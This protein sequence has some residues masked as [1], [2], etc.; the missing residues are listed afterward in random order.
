MVRSIG[1]AG[2]KG[3][4]PLGPCAVILAV[5]GILVVGMVATT[6]VAMVGGYSPDETH[7]REIV[8]EMIPQKTI[9]L[10]DGTT[11]SFEPE[12]CIIHVRTSFFD[13]RDVTAVKINDN[14]I[15]LEYGNNYV[16][17]VDADGS[18]V[19]GLRICDLEDRFI[20][21]SDDF[22]SRGTDTV[23]ICDKVTGVGYSLQNPAP[24]SKGVKNIGIVYPIE[25]DASRETSQ[26]DSV[27][28]VA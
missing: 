19:R 28:D 10:E 21:V 17:M 12:A 14:K 8:V 24:L 9:I 23:L 6:A 27:E 3:K 13:Q 22:D 25:D 2:S 15:A 16:S 20:L 7:N 1:E 11:A 5:I 26:A 18:F 4:F